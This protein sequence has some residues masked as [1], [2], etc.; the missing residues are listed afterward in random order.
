MKVTK[1]NW[2]IYYIIGFIITFAIDLG[3]FGCVLLPIYPDLSI[4]LAGMLEIIWGI[5]WLLYSAH[6]FDF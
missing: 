3:I 4:G 2:W 6:K 1:K 5:G